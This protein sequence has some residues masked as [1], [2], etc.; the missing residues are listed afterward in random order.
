[1]RQTLLLGNWKMNGS[2][3][4]NEVLLRHLIPELLALQ[5]V[6]FGL[7]PPALYL[8]QMLA[9]TR[10]TDIGMGAQHALS[11]PSGAFTGE[12]SVNMLADVGCRYLL[13]GHS[14]RRTLFHQTDAQIGEL[15]AAALQANLVPVLCV[16]ESQAERERG[17]TLATVVRQLNAVVGAVGITAFANAVIAYEPVW[18]IGT[19]LSASPEQAQ[20][21]HSAIRHWL[22]GLDAS[23]ATRIPILYGGSVKPDNALA[24]FRQADIDGGLVGGC[25]LDADAF[26]AIARAL[27]H[28]HQSELG[29]AAGPHA[30]AVCSAH[31]EY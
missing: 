28:T 4:G 17:E 30:E 5:S 25:S 26:L 8:T 3:E 31:P 13:V 7:F 15:F 14:E 18:A 9:L 24:L 19:G 10:H 21:V 12:V 6:A 22:A 2:R 29:R 1:M 23:V 11:Q 16:G 27:D 20:T